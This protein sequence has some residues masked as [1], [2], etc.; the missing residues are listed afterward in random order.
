M[1]ARLA[2][3]ECIL[4]VEVDDAYANLALPGIIAAR[5][6]DSRDAALATELAYGALRMRGLYDAVI[7]KAANRDPAS[8]ETSV[9]T[10]LWLGA[11]QVLAMRVPEHAAVDESV[12]LIRAV[13]NERAAGIVNAV[14]RRITETPLDAWLVR[15]APGRTRS[16]LA[17]RHSHPE[18]I[19]GELDRA[20]QA[21]SRPNEVESLLAAHNEAAKVTLVAR[22]GLADRDRLAEEVRGQATKLSPYGVVL[23][24]GDPSALES[25]RSGAAAAQDEGSQLAALALAHAPVVA[26]QG[27]WL[28]M[29]AGPGGKTALLGGI[30]AQRGAHVDALEL[31]E[32]RTGLVKR[33]VRALPQGAVSVHT[34]DALAWDGEPYDR[35][36]VDAPCTGL[37][38]LRRRPEA[39]WR[40]TAA[41]LAELT[42]L[43][44]R[45]VAKAKTLLRPGGVIAYVTCSPVL[46]ETRDIVGSSGLQLLDTREVLTEATGVD[47]VWGD[48]PAVQLWT[49]AH[50]TDSMFISLLTAP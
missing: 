25:L 50:G 29:C 19:V 49:H 32:H 24:S 30:A 11:H 21:D 45:L 12:R 39:R 22:P 13:G 15:V 7:A 1:S 9:R 23:A 40:R 33:A 44:A 36:L 14:M 5:R 6:L 31:H 43:Q 34:A 17:I 26:D 28:D 2:A 20:L 38:A 41:D 3:Y 10:V 35:I 48:L 16:A 47:G 42:V 4:A 8:L 18:W 37:G 27:R 46:A